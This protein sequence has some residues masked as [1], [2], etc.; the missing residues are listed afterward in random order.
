M[1]HL[2]IPPPATPRKP[3]NR[4]L[5]FST[6]N[7]FPKERIYEQQVKD[8]KTWGKGGCTSRSLENTSPNLPSVS[9]GLLWNSI[10]YFYPAMGTVLKRVSYFRTQVEY[11]WCHNIPK[12]KGDPNLERHCVS[13]TGKLYKFLLYMSTCLTDSTSYCAL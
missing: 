10:K 3:E 8:I 5:I 9:R 12:T 2:V 4:R 13:E 11:W 6:F 7:K 1:Y